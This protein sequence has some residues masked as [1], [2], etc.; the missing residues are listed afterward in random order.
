RF[1]D[2]E[3]TTRVLKELV[4]G[5]E[6]RL[7]EYMAMQCYEAL[8]RATDE[9]SG[10]DVKLWVHLHKVAAPIPNLQG[11]TAFTYSDLPADARIIASD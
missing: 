3:V 5:Q 7:I 11:G 2:Y 10:P 8:R 6:F 4:D 9:L 1:I